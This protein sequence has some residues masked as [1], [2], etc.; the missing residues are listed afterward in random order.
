MAFRQRTDAEK[1]IASL[2]STVVGSCKIR[3]TWGKTQQDKILAWN[4][5]HQ[6]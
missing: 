2:Q 5:Q 3:L 6:V 1:A 4:S